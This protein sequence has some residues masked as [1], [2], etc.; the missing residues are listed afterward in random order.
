MLRV[1]SAADDFD[2]RMSSLRARLRETQRAAKTSADEMSAISRAAGGHVPEELLAGRMGEVGDKLRAA[3]QREERVS[4]Q[5]EESRSAHA[6]ALEREQERAFVVLRQ[7]T[8]RSTL[9][10]AAHNAAD[11]TRREAEMEAAELRRQSAALEQRAKE[12]AARAR[13]REQL[14]RWD[15]ELAWRERD[16]AQAVL[17]SEARLAESTRTLEVHAPAADGSHGDGTGTERTSARD[18]A[19]RPRAWDFGGLVEDADAAAPSAH[20]ARMRAS[21]DSARAAADGAPTDTWRT[22]FREQID[23]IEH[24]LAGLATTQLLSLSEL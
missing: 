21:L 20:L 3:L 23:R 17:Q 24:A 11:T 1:W 14:M 13:E 19:G 16:A 15:L 22:Q 10:E 5:L 6:R 18:V 12:T 4:R 9:L 2:A 7:Q 8:I